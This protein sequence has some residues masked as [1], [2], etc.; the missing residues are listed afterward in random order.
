MNDVPPLAGYTVAVTAARRADELAA[1]L[2]R[3]GAL[4]LRAPAIRIVPLPDDAT[5][6]AATEELLAAPVDLVIATTGIGFRGWI[7]AAEGWG[8][9]H[10]LL[11]TLQ[12]SVVLAR[13]PKAK[14]AVRAAGLVEHWLPSSE[15]SAELLDYLLAS[16]VAGKRIAVQLHGEPLTEFTD[17]LRVAG[18]EIVNIPV[19]RWERAEDLAPLHRLIDAVLARQVDAITFT[20]APAVRSVLA[21]AES[22]GVLAELLT[23]FGTDVL[24]GCV[25]PI[26]ADALLRK[27]IPVVQPDRG[28]LGALVHCVAQRLPERATRLRVGRRVLELRG[29]AVLIDG[30]L[31]AVPPAPMALLRSLAE[32][33]GTVVPR[34]NL[35]A[36]LP[37]GGE[38]HAVESAVGRLRAAL[39]EPR[40]VQTVVK[41]GYRLATDRVVRG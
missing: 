37:G 34:R 33:G 29:H 32:A 2:G 22:T 3:H 6:L 38:E 12:S 20:S 31:R 13:G 9:S 17:A 24:V 35:L 19:Y 16:G 4:V 40:L 39:G 10:K 36:A 25:G 27:A 23:A 14:G 26:T 15:T 18:A 30:E 21:E 7:E 5:L 8:L 41:R 28:R 1:L 11:T